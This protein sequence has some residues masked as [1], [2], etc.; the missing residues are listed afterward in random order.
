MV[1]GMTDQDSFLRK[2]PARC[3]P[4]ALLL[5]SPYPRVWTTR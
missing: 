4:P 2:L 1:N 5:L 3:G